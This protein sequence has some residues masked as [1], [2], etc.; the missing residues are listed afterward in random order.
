MPEVLAGRF[1][2]RQIFSLQF[3]EIAAL[4]LRVVSIS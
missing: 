3:E 4:I 2:M 1:F